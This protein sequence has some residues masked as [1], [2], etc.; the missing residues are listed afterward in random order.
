MMGRR[1]LEDRLADRVRDVES[2]SA[3][4]R[5]AL[6]PVDLVLIQVMYIVGSGWVGTA[7]KL[8]PSHVVFWVLAAATFYLPQ[9]AVVIFLNRL[10][11][12]EGGLYQWAVVGLGDRLGFFVA[13]NLW[14]YGILII[15]TFGVIMATN[16]S[17]LLG[18]PAV[19]LTAS[20]WYTAVVSVLLI[21]GIA[22]VSVRGL[23]V[24]KWLQNAGGVAQLLAFAA[25]I[26]V[27]FLALSR[28]TIQ[29]YHPL[30]TETPKVTLWSLN[31]FGKLA[32]G[33]FSGFEYVALMAG[34][35]R[36]PARSIALSVVVAAPITVLMF[37]LGTSSVL[38][39]VPNAQIDLVSPVPQ[40]LVLGSRGLGVVQ[41][42][43][44]ALIVLI[45]L[46][47]VGNTTL[48]FGGTSRLPMVAGWDGVLPAW[49]TRLH[50]RHRTPANSILFVA[51]VTSALAAA[52]QA[53]VGLQEAFQLLDNAAGILYAL[54]YVALFAIPLVGGGRLSER[55]PVWLRAASLVGLTVTLLYSVL[56][57]FPIIEVASWQVFTAKIL[58]V[59]L[60]ANLAGLVVYVLGRRRLA[61]D[62]R[63]AIA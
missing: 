61:A 10:M 59:L 19:W 21:S 17:Y 62:R 11:P 31:I 16:L 45:L 25:L 4:L 43:A 6:G 1:M 5:R 52:A 35:C 3:A 51:I 55:P 32:L 42:I 36:S 7:A 24:G 27:P 58:T 23:N 56:S 33:A 53:G 13:W 37:V 57:I 28:G 40:A 38:A 26:G 50:P 8:G 2:R 12:L 30:A 49:F 14:A 20:P 46:R 15:A 60:A 48:V 22:A 47:M 18:P 9:A 39:V 41:F 44:P 29:S 63:Q 34:E 54:A